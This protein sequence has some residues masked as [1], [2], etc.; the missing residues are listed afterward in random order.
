MPYSAHTVWKHEIDSNGPETSDE[1]D[2]IL[3]PNGNC[4]EVGIM[5]NPGT[6][7]P[8]LYKEYW[9]TPPVEPGESGGGLR[10]TP[11]VVARTV[12]VPA[13][14]KEKEKQ[15]TRGIIIRVGDYCQALARHGEHEGEQRLL[16][17]RWVI[18]RPAERNPALDDNG[19]GGA[20]EWIKDGRSNTGEDNEGESLMPCVWAC[21]DSR[22]LGDEVVARGVTWRIVEA[23]R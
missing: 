16:V 4:I 1:G 13:K 23:D 22:R 10:K 17:E 21:R 14:E 2:M 8:E 12:A 5:Q 3:L 19:G 20:V 6:G 7:K 15:T 18:T 11:C 9:A